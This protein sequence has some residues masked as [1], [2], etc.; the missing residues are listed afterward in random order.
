MNQTDVEI[1]EYEEIVGNIKYNI[2]PTPIPLSIDQ[3]ERASFQEPTDINLLL[4]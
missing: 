2:N 1:E 3:Q 4:T